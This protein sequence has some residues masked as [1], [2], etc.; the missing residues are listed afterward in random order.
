MTKQD[1]A[2]QDNAAAQGTGADDAQ[3]NGEGAA[4]PAASGN[5]WLVPHPTH[6]WVEDVKALARQHRLQIVDP[7]AAGEAELAAVA[8]DVPELTPRGEVAAAAGTAKA[9]AKP[10]AKS[11]A[12]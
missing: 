6:Q 11:A 4:A 3:T 7:A 2:S 9:A 5:V 10:A 12:K 8:A 1:I